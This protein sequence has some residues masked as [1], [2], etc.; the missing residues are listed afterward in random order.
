MKGAPMRNL[1]TVVPPEVFARLEG[2]AQRAG[3]T[4]AAHVR[5]VLSEASSTPLPPLTK[6]VWAACKTWYLDTATPFKMDQTPRDM[7]KHAV[8]NGF[9]P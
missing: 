6:A 5:N 9:K 7:Y 1:R 2:E 8:Q 3:I 4:L